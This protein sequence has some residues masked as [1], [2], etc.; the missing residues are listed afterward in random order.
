MGANQPAAEPSFNPDIAGNDEASNNSILDNPVPAFPDQLKMVAERT[1]RGIPQTQQLYHNAIIMGDDSLSDEERKKRIQDGPLKAYLDEQGQAVE[2]AYQSSPWYMR[3]T[4]DAG[5]ML[6]GMG[7]SLGEGAAVGA[8]TAATAAPLAAGLSRIPYIGLPLAATVESLGFDQGFMIGTANSM[9]TQAAG[10][11]YGDLINAGIS[12]KAARP[13]AQ[14][15][16]TVNAALEYLSLGKLGK[17]AGK[18]MDYGAKGA[19]SRQLTSPFVKK[20]Q[21]NM[22]AKLGAH[23]VESIAT[24]SSTEYMQT[25]MEHVAEYTAHRVERSGP[26]D[27]DWNAAHQSSKEA[28]MQAL[29]ASIMLGAGSG[30][31]GYA[32][33]KGKGGVEAVLNNQKVREILNSAEKIDPSEMLSNINKAM[34]EMPYPW[35]KEGANQV[36]HTSDGKIF[37]TT[38]V[39]K[40]GEAG[41]Q[42]TELSASGPGPDTSKLTPE[43]V[44]GGPT[45][46]TTQAQQGT[47]VLEIKDGKLQVSQGAQEALGKASE[48]LAQTGDAQAA[49]DTLF[50]DQ[51]DNQ[52]VSP[53]QLDAN[54]REIGPA[55]EATPMTALEVQARKNQIASDLKTLKAEEMRL[56][57]KFKQQE[58]IGRNSDATIQKLESVWEK[59]A[60]LDNERGLLELGLLSRENVAQDSGKLRMSQISKL[61]TK[62]QKS[63]DRLER[64]KQKLREKVSALNLNAK[65]AKQEAI[66]KGNEKAAKA[67]AAGMKSGAFQENRAIRAMQDQLIQIV[68]AATSDRNTRN[69]LKAM[70][71]KVT[72]RTQFNKV[73]QKMQAKLGKILAKQ[74]AR[75]YKKQQDAIVGQIDKLLNVGKTRMSGGKPINAKLDADTTARLNMFKN[76][77][78]D[79]QSA[80]THMNNFMTRT[81]TDSNGVTTDYATLLATGQGHLIPAKDL[82]NFN[83]ASMAAGL[84]NKS[85]IELNIIKGN[86]AQWVQDGRDAVARKQAAIAQQRAAESAIAA[87]SIGANKDAYEGLPSPKQVA[88]QSTES[89]QASILNWDDLMKFISPNDETHAIAQLV[90]PT[91]ARRNYYTA[92]D[93]IKLGALQAMEKA[94]RQAGS[95]KSIQDK[96]NEDSN[97]VYELRY[98]KKG[99]TEATA[100]YN[101]A[102]LIDIWMKMQDPELHDT[103]TDTAK[104]NGWTFTGDVTQGRSFEETVESI[105]EPEDLA[106]G[107]SLLDF[108][109]DYHSRVNTAFRDKYGAD[110]PKRDNY[111]PL[112]RES[113]DVV[114]GSQQAHNLMFT[115]L[116][117]GSA[118]SRVNSLKAIKPE[119]AYNIMNDHINGWEHF[120][121]FDEI[122]GTMKNVFSDS[123]INKTIEQRHGYGTKKVIDSYVER[124]VSDTAMAD[125]NDGANWLYRAMRSDI[126]KAAL[127]FKAVYQMGTQLTSGVAMWGDHNIADIAKGYGYYIKN[128]Q[129][130]EKAMRDSPILSRRF[131]EGNSIDIEQALRQ[132]GIGAELMTR[133]FGV[134]QVELGPKQYDVLTRLMFDGIRYGDAGVARVFG[135]A[136][137]GA[138]RAAGKSKQEAIMAVERAMERTQQ[139]DTV[140]QIPNFWAKNPGLYTLFGMFKLQP[141]Q[142]MSHS[143]IAVRDFQNDILSAGRSPQK[144]AQAFMKLGGKS[145]AYWLIP[146]LLYGMVKSM[147]SLVAPP[148]DDPDR[149]RENAFDMVTQALMGPVEGVP[150]VSDMVEM[151]WFAA[152]KPLFGLDKKQTIGY[153]GQNNF[154]KTFVS[155]PWEAMQ[156]WTKYFKQ[157]NVGKLPSTGKFEDKDE[158][159]DKALLKTSRAASPIF[160]VPAALVNTP[161]SIGKALEQGD[162]LGAMFALGGWSPGAIK[163]RLGNVSA[164]PPKL[165]NNGAKQQEPSMYDFIDGYLQHANDNADQSDTDGE[166]Q[167]AFHK[168][169]EQG[170]IDENIGE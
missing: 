95:Q 101:K 22:F 102:Q 81:H 111:S 2:S 63:A 31:G 118:K 110:L 87:S 65:T 143:L 34:N 13:I 100:R 165:P 57:D 161:V 7:A 157:D 77:V 159:L 40:T 104:G 144:A 119:N 114:P 32:I 24:E 53:E 107:Q 72:T 14:A 136:V 5:N 73:T 35:E 71:N 128:F 163:D 6:P 94:L 67:K 127:G 166:L 70:I 61:V 113:H 83:L 142:M 48:T 10:E 122:L 39:S 147:P 155:N 140:E 89:L 4:A 132:N 131:R 54:A 58:Q 68:N 134:D 105:L 42:Q 36:H 124:F 149:N 33:G 28:F 69:E 109:D 108:Y 46:E 52:F 11:I 88:K 145:L 56:S 8:G 139:G 21:S 116:L 15:Y 120:M 38:G 154:T 27:F 80:V 97:S 84:K 164:G 133:L 50:T 45:G 30:L 167:D 44:L 169:L 152:A 66:Q 75:D 115:S 19:I 25:F 99:N 51:Q 162:W 17:L 126:S 78:K 117:P 23:Y 3:M 49:L 47:P 150:L 20:L 170:N 137:Y 135:G 160:G 153:L 9:Q 121:A 26:Q 93:T 123:N 16:G 125:N 43:E 168:G 85:P 92:Q 62:V 129:E 130:A 96:M 37:I 76:F 1:Y 98:L 12:H 82:F 112:S 151:M 86:I 106:V 60:A 91:Q 158:Q 59:Q 74:G 79:E 90:D 148:G 103:M 41:T 138:E 141:Q 156:A 146:G 64:Q 55:M 29:G 18:A